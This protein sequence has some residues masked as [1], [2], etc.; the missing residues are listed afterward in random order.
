MSTDED[1]ERRLTDAG[2]HWRAANAR[3]A[4]VSFEERTS[5]SRHALTGA[6]SAAAVIAL[7][8]GLA[9][10]LNRGTEPSA[11][12]G[13]GTP[14]TTARVPASGKPSQ[15]AGT[16][17]LASIVEGSTRVASADLARDTLAF[18]HGR[19][20]IAHRC[21]I[22]EAH[23]RAGARTLD[24]TAVQL[25]SAL[26]C[27]ATPTQR[28]EQQ[29][30]DAMD[31]TLAGTSHWSIDGSTLTVTKGG[32]TLHFRRTHTSLSMSADEPPALLTSTWQ[33]DGIERNSGNSASGSGSSR[34]AAIHVNYASGA[35]VVSHRCYVVTVPTTLGPRTLDLGTP[36]RDDHSCP[37]A[38]GRDTYDAT[39]DDVLSGHVTWTIDGDD[40]HIAKGGTT[41]DFT[42][43]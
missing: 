37:Y 35:L 12:A 33:L 39:V 3:R 10:W 25:V 4:T 36:T 21:Y 26:P 6:L 19:L 1:L 29:H 8:V 24:V 30:T 7:A 2:A 27:P 43:S 32:T 22:D 23:V 15:L 5:R 34:M 9:V 42:A 16:W 14:R 20:V 40:L 31:S 28:Q 18:T 41:L 11:I 13:S 38:P 17:Q